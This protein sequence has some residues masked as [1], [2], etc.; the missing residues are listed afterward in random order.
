LS[1]PERGWRAVKDRLD[2][3]R[4][5]LVYRGFIQAMRDLFD[6]NVERLDDGN[7]RQIMDVLLKAAV[8]EDWIPHVLRGRCNARAV[9]WESHYEDYLSRAEREL[10]L[11]VL[12][13]DIFCRGVFQE[14]PVWKKPE[15]R[16]HIVTLGDLVDVLDAE[17]AHCRKRGGA[18]V[19]CCMAYCRDLGFT[20]RTYAE[21]SQAF[22]E[23]Q[24]E[25]T[26]ESWRCLSDFIVWRSCET[27]ARCGLP[28]QVHTGITY[29]DCRI[30]AADPMRLAPLI[31]AHPETRFLLLHGAYPL[32]DGLLALARAFDNVWV[33]GSWMPVLSAEAME[34]YLESSLESLPANKILLWGGDSL[35]VEIT[36]GSLVATKHALARVL[37][38][39]IEAGMET[40]SSAIR[41]AR[42]ILFENA[43]EFYGLNAL[44]QV[45]AAIAGA[46]G[47]TA[48]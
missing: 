29:G 2:R 13:V 32:W 42:R 37:C 47:K 44:Q 24:G 23:C 33:D 21:A 9:I 11:P 30:A 27:A 46:P 48:A 7:W 41:L 31:A 36:Y 43:V 38:R 19:K 28:V 5:T 35:R 16:K 17:I 25:G 39:R 15:Y 6:L 26:G 10:F 12:L 1:D 4:N 14:D 40:E 20:Q 45:K 22:A 3:V 18:A 34:A 8:R